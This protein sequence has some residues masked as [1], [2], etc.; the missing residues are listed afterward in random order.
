MEQGGNIKRSPNLKGRWRN[1]LKKARHE[2]VSNRKANV[3]D[4]FI[5]AAEYLI[6]LKKYM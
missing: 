3:F 5:A 2:Q 6:A 4:D 1:W